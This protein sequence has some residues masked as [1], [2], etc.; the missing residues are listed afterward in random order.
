MLPPLKQGH[1]CDIMKIL[2]REWHRRGSHGITRL[3]PFLNDMEH[4]PLFAY[5]EGFQEGW[6]VVSNTWCVCT[7]GVLYTPTEWIFLCLFIPAGLAS[8]I[9]YNTGGFSPKDMLLRVDKM[10]PS[11]NEELEMRLNETSKCRYKE[12]NICKWEFLCFQLQVWYKNRLQHAH[13]KKMWVHYKNCISI[14][15]FVKIRFWKPQ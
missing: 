12:F 13:L 15:Y 8:I 11:W 5:Q 1:L 4:V 14:E 3:A 6:G 2:I 7:K 10:V 9:M